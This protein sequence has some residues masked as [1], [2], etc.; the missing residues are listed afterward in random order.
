MKPNL[1]FRILEF[2]IAGLLIDLVE[3][4]VT[5]KFATHEPITWQVVGVAFLVV[6][7]FAI[8]TEL[9]IDHPKFWERTTAIWRKIFPPRN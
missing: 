4:M 8:I 2:I 7:P 6:I 3:N 5:V 9:V 1:K